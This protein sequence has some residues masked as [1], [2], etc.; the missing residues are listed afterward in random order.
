MDDSMPQD[1]YFE[2]EDI[3][4][5]RAPYEVTDN[6]KECQ[7]LEY[8]RTFTHTFEE[9]ESDSD[10]F[11]WGESEIGGEMSA[12]S[13]T[14]S[15][16]TSFTFKSF[17]DSE[18][19]DSPIDFPS[20]E[21]IEGIDIGLGGVETA[22][23]I[24]E[25]MSFPDPPATLQK[26]AVDANPSFERPTVPETRDCSALCLQPCGNV[27]YLLHQW[28][29]DDVSA[30][31][32]HLVTKRK[33]WGD[34]S[35]LDHSSWKRH[36]TVA[37]LE[38]ASWRTWSKL[39]FGLKTVSPQTINWLKNCDDTCL[40]GPFS[41]SS[42]SW[43]TTPR[44]SSPSSCTSRAVR[45]PKNK[46]DSC[47]TTPPSILKKPSI[48]D[49]LR[50]GS[51]PTYS[52]PSSSSSLA[53]TS[54]QG[55]PLSD[56]SP[57]V[58]LQTSHQHTEFTTSIPTLNNSQPKK[59]VKF[60][61]EVRQYIIVNPIG[62][63]KIHRTV[64]KTRSKTLEEEAYF[65]DPEPVESVSEQSYW[66]PD[67]LWSYNQPPTQSRTQAQKQS[68]SQSQEQKDTEWT[69]L[70]VVG[71]D[72]TDYFSSKPIA[73]DP[74]TA[75]TPYPYSQPTST[76]SPTSS[77]SDIGEGSLSYYNNSSSNNTTDLATEIETEE[78]NDPI[79]YLL[80][81]TSTPG[82][83]SE[84]LGV[85][86]LSPGSSSS[87][88]DEQSSAS[89]ESSD[90]EAPPVESDVGEVKIGGPVRGLGMGVGAG[91]G[92]LGRGVGMRFGMGM[93][94][95]IVDDEKHRLYE[96]VMEEFNLEY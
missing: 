78:V 70:G 87:G 95:G 1:E 9:G 6:G 36:N 15:I 67:S 7:T 11:Q 63:R 40:Y 34:I 10:D 86:S 29:E 58:H 27:N 25:E 60:L 59:N 20:Y 48:A 28:R 16:Q 74:T 32:R 44:P 82:S 2:W 69:W 14:T 43:E 89:E 88:S 38:N 92:V 80:S 64:K 13:S 96:Q 83:D 57:L 94:I 90:D 54:V 37:R 53:F 19:K 72:E 35:Q 24:V 71:E 42:R 85:G 3:I 39:R 8:R 84:S 79:D 5:Y 12:S 49:I 52:L 76:S 21:G 73:T 56:N 45:T 22:T 26:D 61:S 55:C 75:G 51:L 62:D 46:S 50:R 77:P 33:T 4:L 65:L 23:P 91:A 31:W 93:G 17:R 41:V 68:T 30:S 81:C 47:T 18:K 66:S